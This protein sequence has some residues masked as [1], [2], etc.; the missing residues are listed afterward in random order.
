MADRPNLIIICSDEMRGDCTGFAGNPDVKT[1]NLDR[2]ADEAIAFTNHTS[3]FPK[4]VPA[5]ISLMTGR[6]CHTDGYR[7]LYQHLVPDHVNL[8]DRFNAH[9]YQT[10]VFGKNH[11]W[12]PRVFEEEIDYTSH[13]APYDEMMDGVPR[14]LETE[15]DPGSPTPLDLENGWQYV[16]CNT[17]H[18]ADEAYAR[19]AIDFLEHRRNGDR[20]FFLEINFESPHPV[21]GVEEPWYG[22]Y[23]RDTITPW[24]HELPR[25][26]PLPTV[27]QRE[28]RTGMES[29][30]EAALEVQRVYYGMISKLDMLI[31]TVLD[32]LEEQGLWEDTVV[33]FW[34]DHGDYAGQY[35]LSEKWDTCFTDCLVQVP[36]V[37]RAPGLP[38][39]VRVDA[40]SDHTDLAPTLCELLDFEPLPGMHGHSLL[41]TL[42]GERVRTATFSEGG[43][44]REMW[45]RFTPDVYVETPD[46]GRKR[47]AKTQTYV[48]CPET[49]ARA[50]M[51]RTERYKMVIRLIG[52]NELYDLKED[53][54]ELDNRW[55]D[56][57]LAPVVRDLQQQ[58]LEWCIRTDTDRPYQER[59]QV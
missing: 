44:E 26:A 18:M 30:E 59:V 31:G 6:Y 34:V 3:V 19:Q 21:Y 46:G 39:G 4:C 53:P 11:C 43:H 35:T 47:L 15:P 14:L 54:W 55:G 36:C 23:E 25:N 27:K 17:R 5:R 32:A 48:D 33:L 12:D 50:K 49:M 20:P 41:P 13:R 10:A 58:L 57:A 2:F 7:N 1:P 9:G 24:P 52:G 51:I 29:Q 28:I 8:L 42:H 56:P 40:L 37:L 45:E 22:M 38:A 16:G